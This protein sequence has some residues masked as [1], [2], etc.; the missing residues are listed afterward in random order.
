LI[1]SNGI[2]IY[3]QNIIDFRANEH[4]GIN[5]DDGQV[6][7]FRIQSRFGRAGMQFVAYLPIVNAFIN[8]V[9]APGIQLSYKLLG[10][11]AVDPPVD[12][13]L[14]AIIQSL[15]L[16]LAEHFLPGEIACVH[17]RR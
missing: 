6:V 4:V 9:D 17:P 14:G 12:D 11:A 15:Q 13:N 2:L 7:A 1:D 5:I 3:I 16:R 8:I 10:P